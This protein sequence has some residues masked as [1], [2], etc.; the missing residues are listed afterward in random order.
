MATSGCFIFEDKNGKELI[1]F[2]Q[3]W[4]CYL[5]GAVQQVLNAVEK[6]GSLRGIIN[7]WKNGGGDPFTYE[8]IDEPDE[9]MGADRQYIINV[10]KNTFETDEQTFKLEQLYSL[11]DDEDE[12]DEDEEDEEDDMWE[13]VLDIKN[14]NEQL[15]KYL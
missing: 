12:D 9:D 2:Y 15:R 3:H 1:R 11:V 5:S 13:S 14:L 4:D 6:T 10:D 7:Y 8:V